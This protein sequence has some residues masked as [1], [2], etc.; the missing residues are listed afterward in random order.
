MTNVKIKNELLK[1]M[2]LS[3]NRCGNS[4]QVMIFEPEFKIESLNPA[5]RDYRA[6]F[7]MD[8][9]WKKVEQLWSDYQ[10]KCLEVERLRKALEW[11]FKMMSVEVRIGVK[12]ELARQN[13]LPPPAAGIPEEADE[14]VAARK[15]K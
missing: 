6:H 5:W 14:T 4:L 13:L 1:Y 10:A 15:D 3:W 11:A 2:G 12:A 8:G 7:E 9:A